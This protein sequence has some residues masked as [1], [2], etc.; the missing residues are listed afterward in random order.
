M[1]SLF[2]LHNRLVAAEDAVVYAASLIAARALF[3]HLPDRVGGAKVALIC[4]FD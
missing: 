3:G 1:A 4:V 2:V